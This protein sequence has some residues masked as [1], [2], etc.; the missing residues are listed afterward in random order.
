MTA[1]FS[2]YG[3]DAGKSPEQLCAERSKRLYDAIQLKQPD[4]IPIQINFGSMIAELAGVTRQELYENPEKMRAALVSAA[5]RFQPDS[6]GGMFGNPDL[7]R[8]LGDRTTRWPGY[9][10]E[11]NGSFQ[12]VEDE[13]MK[14]EDY[15]DFLEDPTDWA[16]RVYLPRIFGE[17]EGL[18]EL[19]PLAACTLKGYVGMLLNLGIYNPEP[20]KNALRVLLQAVEV[21]SEWM[22]Q[23]AVTGQRMAEAGFPTLPLMQTYMNAPFD[24]M[25]DTLRGMR[26]LFTDMRR[27]PEKLL[28]GE[29][30]WRRMEV[31][32][33]LA[34]HRTHPLSFAL[35]PLHRGS[36]GFIS[37]D[38]FERFY[39]PQLKSLFMTCI[40]N[41]ITPYV[42]YE[43]VWDQ[44]LKYLA[45]LPKG[46]TVGYFDNTDLI[47]A[48]EV[49]GDTMCIVGGMKVSLLAGG[50][51]EEV[52]DLTKRHCQVV[53]KGGG[54]I[55]TSN[56][57]ELEGCNPELIKT[58]VDATREFGTY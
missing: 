58:W 2:P 19:P 8:V 7:A 56:A 42:F 30:K 22:A 49:I 39:W 57:G 43:G 18:A 9:G 16:A 47:K 24:C 35:F 15:D 14:A 54:Y 6:A 25:G 44:R 40:E 53:G 41:G 12:M 23:Q 55:M 11:A 20:I 17:L 28:A 29:E 36:D 10:L 13:Y 31:K 3:S 52:R 37:L 50:T 48:K 46:K 4:R 27:R 33:L 1:I 38:Q 5:L 51:V 32:R 21:R 34:L 45:E 26:G